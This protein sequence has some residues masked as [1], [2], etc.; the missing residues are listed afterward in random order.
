MNLERRGSSN[1][2]VVPFVVENRRDGKDARIHLGH[3][4][5]DLDAE[6]AKERVFAEIGRLEKTVD[7]LLSS[8]R[9]R[10]SSLKQIAVRGSHTSTVDSPESPSTSVFR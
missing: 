1:H 4:R 8:H 3:L 7:S 6:F 9:V 5:I 10:S 2:L